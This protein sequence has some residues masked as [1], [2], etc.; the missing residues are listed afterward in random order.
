L[1]KKF[2]VPL[3][4]AWSAR[5]GEKI[6]LRDGYVLTTAPATHRTSEPYDPSAISTMQEIDMIREDQPDG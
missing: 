4:F 3:S 1:W 5:R 2:N 6:E